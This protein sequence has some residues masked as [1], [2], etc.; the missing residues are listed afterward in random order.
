MRILI[1]CLLLVFGW[2]QYRLWAGEGSLAELHALKSDIARHRQDLTELRARNQ[3]LAAEVAD[4]KTGQEALEERARADLGMIRHGEVFVQVI[5][6][7]PVG[8]PEPPPDTKPDI[9]PA[10]KPAKPAG[11]AAAQAGAGPAPKKGGQH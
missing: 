7:A 2:L 4:L 3:A 11:P 10:A 1:L 5:E 9:K 8:A 6:G